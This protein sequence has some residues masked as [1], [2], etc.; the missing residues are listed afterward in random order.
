M[1]K[2]GENLLNKM[3]EKQRLV[4]ISKYPLGLGKT[5]YVTDLCEF[6]LS[7]KSK[8]ITGQNLIIDGGYSIKS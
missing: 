6:L 8:W 5:E 7:D 3:T 1:T 4:E 2:M